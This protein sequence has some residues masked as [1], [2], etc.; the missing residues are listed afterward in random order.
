MYVCICARTCKYVHMRARIE[1]YMCV[2]GRL[3]AFVFSFSFSAAPIASVRRPRSPL[4]RRLLLSSAVENGEETS[5]FI[6][7]GER[8]GV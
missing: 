7:H 5:S 1:A 2:F 3:S 4:R 6:G 8:R